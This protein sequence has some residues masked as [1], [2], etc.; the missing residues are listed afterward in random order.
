MTVRAAEVRARKILSTAH[1]VFFQCDLIFYDLSGSGHI[2]PTPV[3][4]SCSVVCFCIYFISLNIFSVLIRLCF[5][6][7]LSR[8]LLFICLPGHVTCYLAC[9]CPLSLFFLLPFALFDCF[10]FSTLQFHFSQYS[11]FCFPKL[12]DLLP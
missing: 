8:V 12:F 5:V 6:T 11:E 3:F 9:R 4:P 10:S 2:S 7:I 1:L